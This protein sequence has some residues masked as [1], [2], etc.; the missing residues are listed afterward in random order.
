[1]KFQNPHE[2]GGAYL[3]LLTHS[4]DFDPEMVDDRTPY[5]IMFGPDKCGTT[6]KVHLHP[7]FRHLLS[8]VFK[9][10]FIFRHK[11]RKTGVAEEKQLKNPPA[12]VISKMFTLYTLIVRADN[13]FDI[14]VNGKSVREGSLFQ[15]FEP[16]VNPP[17]EIDDP[18]DVKPAE[19]ID[20][21]K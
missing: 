4:P 16:P 5:T 15:D 13:T 3:K 7:N 11:N 20:D 1:M 6:N 14:L 21:A 18:N 2:C 9:V 12:A 17:K 10:H 19:W 8:H